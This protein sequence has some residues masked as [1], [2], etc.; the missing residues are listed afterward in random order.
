VIIISKSSNDSDVTAHVDRRRHL[1]ATQR[2]TTTLPGARTHGRSAF[3]PKS[4]P[5]PRSTIPCL[6]RASLQDG[7]RAGHEGGGSPGGADIP[8][9]RR[10]RRSG[11]GAGGK[12]VHR[13]RCST[14]PPAPGPLRDEP[15]DAT[16]YP[17]PAP[18]VLRQD[19]QR[20]AVRV[21]LAA[22]NSGHQRRTEVP[23]TRSSAGITWQGR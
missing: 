4:T 11:P 7:P 8:S 3:T 23:A 13:M 15:A 14:L 16:G 1:T 10:R 5:T 19:N 17:L 2:H 22:V 18:P 21:L 9:R 12:V 20:R 6:R